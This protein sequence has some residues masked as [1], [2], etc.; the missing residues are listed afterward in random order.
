MKLTIKVKK[1]AFKLYYAFNFYF[2]MLHL[3]TK[4]Q[5]VNL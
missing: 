4:K 1:L 5:A 2:Y 3:T